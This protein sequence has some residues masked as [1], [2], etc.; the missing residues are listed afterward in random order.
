MSRRA[1]ELCLFSLGDDVDDDVDDSSH[2]CVDS[3]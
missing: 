2:T 3:F 1:A